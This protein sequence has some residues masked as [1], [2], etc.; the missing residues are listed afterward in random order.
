MSLMG[1][2]MHV[3][4]KQLS[5]FDN[6]IFCGTSIRKQS[7]QGDIR[8]T[9]SHFH[10]SF[11]FP[12]GGNTACGISFMLRKSR[13]DEKKIISTV[14]PEDDSDIMGRLA[15][16]RY[17]NGR[18]DIALLGSYFPT[19]PNSHA[20]MRNYWRVCNSMLAWIRTHTENL[21][22]R[23]LLLSFG[24]FNDDFGSSKQGD[25]F[26]DVQSSCIGDAR[27]GKEKF[28]GTRFRQL[29]ETLGQGICSIFQKT[30]ATC[31]GHGHKTYLDTWTIPLHHIREV[32]EYRTMP[33][34]AAAFRTITSKCADHVPVM[35]F[36]F[37]SL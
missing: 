15:I 3:V 34:I 25:N 4:S 16:I 33:R 12:I 10:F 21:P 32:T 6:M 35:V 5:N 37:H 9:N 2:R 31:C 1:Y 30:K 26:V 18:E 19:K 7:L 14:T 17:R 22:G 11:G 23:C 36:M 28:I 13:F 24:D 27:R 8:H 20:T 29:C